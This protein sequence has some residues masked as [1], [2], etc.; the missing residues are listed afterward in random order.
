[1]DKTKFQLS[2]QEATTWLII[3]K[4]QGVSNKRK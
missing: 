1:M 2:L 3:A 4:M